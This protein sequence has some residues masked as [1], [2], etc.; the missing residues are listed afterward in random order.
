MSYDW[1]FNICNPLQKGLL[2]SDK[3][4]KHYPFL[5]CIIFITLKVN[6]PLGLI[7]LASKTVIFSS[8]CILAAWEITVEESTNKSHSNQ[9]IPIRLPSKAACC[10]TFQFSQG[11]NNPFQ[12]TLMYSWSSEKIMQ[13]YAHYWQG[14]LEI[15]MRYIHSFIT[16]L[17][18]K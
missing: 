16:F 18:S 10:R 15:Y 6:I 11:D 12:K 14:D 13:Y 17:N 8:E 3:K 2:F 9:H 1:K 5:Y 7:A 4:K